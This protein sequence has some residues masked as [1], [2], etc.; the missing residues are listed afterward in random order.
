M[1]SFE[2]FSPFINADQVGIVVSDLAETINQYGLILGVDSFE[3][4][5]WPIPGKDPQATYYGGPANYSMR[6]G[7]VQIGKIQLEIVQPLDGK[8]IFKDF[9]ENHGPGLHHIRFSE[10]DFDFKVAQMEKA[11]IKMIASGSGV[12]SSSKWAYFDTTQILG[13]I[14]IEIRSLV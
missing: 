12:R 8:S 2:L 14:Y 10:K 1:D 13:G 6:I 9:L 5:D 3:I 7:F 4:I 11:G